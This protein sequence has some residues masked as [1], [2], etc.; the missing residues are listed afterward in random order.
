MHTQMSRRM[1]RWSR[2]VL[3]ALA[4]AAMAPALSA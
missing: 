2:A 4:L 3:A 1:S